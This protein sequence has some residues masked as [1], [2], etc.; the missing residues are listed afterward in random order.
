MLDVALHRSFRHYILKSDLVGNQILKC[1][2]ELVSG[3]YNS[4]T[5]SQF[6]QVGSCLTIRIKLDKIGL[7]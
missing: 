7:Y 5:L 1:H 6:I 4:A 2:P 3:S